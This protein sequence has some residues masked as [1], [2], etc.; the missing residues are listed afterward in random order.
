MLKKKLIVIKINSSKV[1]LVTFL[2]NFIRNRLKP[3][4]NGIG[5]KSDVLIVY[6]ALL[7]YAILRKQINI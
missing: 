1:R 5:T 6:I 3:G 4:F 2:I 7:Y